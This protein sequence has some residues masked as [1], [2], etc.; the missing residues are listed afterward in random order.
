MSLFAEL[1]RRNVIRMPGCTWWRVVDRAGGGHLAA[2]V[3]RAG[4]GDEDD[5]RLLAVAFVPALVFAWV[6]ELTPDGIKRDAEVSP[7]IDRA[8]DAQ[9]MNRSIF[10]VLLLAL[11][12]FGFDK[13]VLA[14]RREA[15][16]V[17]TA[18]KKAVAAAASVVSDKSIAVLPFVNMSSDRTRNISP[19]ASARKS[20]MGWRRCR[21]Q[22][23]R[24]ALPASSSRATTKTYA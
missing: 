7:P 23:G 8:A 10:V 1:K 22:G 15:V 5:R 20:S 11:G 4:L 6:F 2:G 19:T 24:S 21:P 3:R 9:R 16:M 12:Y 17:T 13:F 14:P 18:E